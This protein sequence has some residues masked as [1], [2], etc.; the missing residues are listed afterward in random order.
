M[1]SFSLVHLD[2]SEGWAS[3]W[4]RDDQ[5]YGSQWDFEFQCDVF[6]ATQGRIIIRKNAGP[7]ISVKV[8]EYHIGVVC[9]DGIQ[10][11]PGTGA[12]LKLTLKF[13]C[14]ILELFLDDIKV[15]E[16][17]DSDLTEATRLA[18]PAKHYRMLS[19]MKLLRRAEPPEP[20]EALEYIHQIKEFWGDPWTKNI[21]EF[22]TSNARGLKMSRER[23]VGWRA[24]SI[25]AALRPNAAVA[26]GIPFEDRG[27][28]LLVRSVD[29]G[30]RSLNWT[31]L[32][33]CELQER[34]LPNQSFSESSFVDFVSS[35]KLGHYPE[36]D[37]WLMVWI[38]TADDRQLGIER[39]R[40]LFKK[41]SMLPFRF[42]VGLNASPTANNIGI[43]SVYAR[44]SKQHFI[45]NVDMATSQFTRIEFGE[46]GQ[47]IEKNKPIVRDDADRESWV[48]QLF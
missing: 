9:F 32:Q 46:N 1:I 27:A 35:T 4:A 2:I 38:R 15:A 44:D 17:A 40:Q 48:A 23:F 45:I 37:D 34:F 13:A 19:E 5:Y 47:D 33:V 7:L 36:S 30:K 16:R 26:I 21:A 31:G 43:F 41:Q 10:L 3:G 28:D 6:F 11:P 14:G 18:L 25:L 22:S 12:K 29:K 42:I 8:S 39:V 24:M 20:C